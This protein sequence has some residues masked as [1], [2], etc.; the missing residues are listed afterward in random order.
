MRPVVKAS[1][2]TPLLQLPTSSL[3]VLK[4]WMYSLSFLPLFCRTERRQA[5]FFF[6]FLLAVNWL[7]NA[8][9]KSLK[10]VIESHRRLLNLSF[11]A[12]LRAVGNAMHM[13]GSNTTWSLV[14]LEMIVWISAP[15][16]MFI[17]EYLEFQKRR[18]EQVD[19]QKE[20]ILWARMISLVSSWDNFPGF[21][22]L[23]LVDDFL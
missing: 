15:I 20:I 17:R 5:E 1:I 6:C 7:Q 11:A 14:F 22:P 18:S 3:S 23:L 21:T 12:F 2:A 10:E 13:K 4:H 19:S 9:Y 8:W 16:I